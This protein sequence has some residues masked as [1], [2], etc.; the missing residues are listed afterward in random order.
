MLSPPRLHASCVGFNAV[1]WTHQHLSALAI[2]GKS[3]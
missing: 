2:L 3:R 1:A